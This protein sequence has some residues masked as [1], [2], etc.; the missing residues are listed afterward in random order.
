MLM[1]SAS[2]AVADGL[3]VPMDGLEVTTTVAPGGEGA[4][5][6]T[7]PAGKSTELL[8]IDPDGG[9]V[10]ASRT[11]K[12]DFTIPLVALDGTSAGLSADGDTLALITP[13][14][15]FRRFPRKQT[16]FVVVDVGETG[17]MHPRKPVTL[18]GDFSFDAL[19]PDGRA[20][21]LVEYVSADYNDYAVRKYDLTRRRLLED[22]V[23]F[24]H[25]VEPGEMRGLPMARATSADGRRAYTL[26]NGG[27]R[28]SDEAFIH[29]LDT[30]DG[31]SHCIDLTQ[32][33]GVEAWELKLDLAPGGG[34]LD[35]LRGDRSLARM[36]TKT[37]AVTEPSAAEQATSEARSDG[38]G[39]SGVA[40]GAAHRRES[41]SWRAR[42]SRRAL[43][44]SGSAARP[45]ASARRRPGRRGSRGR[46]R[47]LPGAIQSCRPSRR[48]PVS[49]A[50]GGRVASSENVVSSSSERSRSVSRTYQSAVFS[51]PTSRKVM[52]S[53]EQCSA[54]CHD[55]MRVTGTRRPDSSCQTP[56]L[57]S[58]VT[59]AGS[60]DGSH[61]A[62]ERMPQPSSRFQSRTSPAARR[63]TFVRPSTS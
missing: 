47:R 1:G 38:G 32:I 2:Q 48:R 36:D 43:T 42:L 50:S 14:T 53:Q 51:G 13:R 33:S 15:S 39:I 40:I 41:R 24:S 7:V 54:P 9:E 3:P 8:R 62:H 30:V 17:R 59:S 10:T 23:P 37:Y 56:M 27:G 18:R 45:P 12:G 26:Y 58:S 20:M 52:S 31:I 63:A 44:R 4:R 25:V 11:I 5:Y 55:W 19:S 61:C 57:R 21:Y 49:D 6:A 35:V 22:P 60:S 46:P 34:A 16:S 29:M 28:K